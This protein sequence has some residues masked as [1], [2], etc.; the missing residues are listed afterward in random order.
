MPGKVV[1][2]VMAALTVGTLF[3][4]SLT[5]GHAPHNTSQWLAPIGPAV[6]VGGLGLWV[7]DRYAWRWRGVR[8]LTG[9]PVL[10]GTWHGELASD[11]VDPK[12]RERIPADPDVFLVVRQRFWQVS[13]RLLTRESASA[14][15]L[16]NFT[17]GAD[18]VH[19]LLW[20]YSNTPRPEVRH[21]SELHHGAAI[22]S[23]PRDP[24]GLEGQYFTDRKTTG[25]L[26][27]TR[28]YPQLVE[29]HSAGRA[30]VEAAG[31]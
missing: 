8:R 24:E 21:R 11:W 12:T 6:T 5:H 15:T 22:L 20:V 23:A 31:G 14:S 7:F 17:V 4:L 3:V 27:F 16:A 29:T 13:A 25:E 28:R 18:G 2:Y 26:R 30:L 19:Q 1:L 10:H 9:R